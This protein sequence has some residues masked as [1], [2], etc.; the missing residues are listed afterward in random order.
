MR[1]PGSPL[2]RLIAAG[3]IESAEEPGGV[4]DIEPYPFPASGSPAASEVLGQARQTPP[5]KP[6]SRPDEPPQGER[7]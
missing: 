7:Q 1:E 5:R 3:I 2:E 6:R 4:G